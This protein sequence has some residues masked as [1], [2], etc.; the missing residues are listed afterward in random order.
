MMRRA[1]L[2]IGCCIL[3]AANARADLNHDQLAEFRHRLDTLAQAIETGQTNETHQAAS[4]LQRWA[5]KQ[6]TSWPIDRLCDRALN[7]TRQL[8]DSLRQLSANLDALQHEPDGPDLANAR[9]VLTQVLSEGEYQA[10]L[11]PN[12]WQQLV[13]RLMSWIDR[14]MRALSRI[15]GAE[16][17]ASVI[18][19]VAVA[20]LLV[21]LL[22]VIGYL[23]WWQFQQHRAAP[24]IATTGPTLQL[25]SPETHLARANEFLRLGQS[26]EAIKQFHLAVLATL[27]QRGLVVPDRTRTNW[28]YLAQFET[29]SA[30]PEPVS[31]LRWLNR[32][33]DR[34]VFGSQPCDEVL[35]LEFGKTSQQLMQ[36]VAAGSPRA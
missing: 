23:V 14:L 33:Y 11:Q 30:A 27:E 9:A 32:L 34:A 20:L 5:R 7:D 3:L 4:A 21:P 13:T 35:A 29:K 17:I 36:S 16:K 1:V 24:Q 25:E 26:T 2:S 18:F 28:E 19:C 31:L 22:A 12:W 8:R 15:P 6:D 10:A